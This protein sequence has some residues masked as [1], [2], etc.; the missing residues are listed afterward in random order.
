MSERE[1]FE[2][3]GETWFR[4]QYARALAR[5]FA[6]SRKTGTAAKGPHWD[7]LEA[8]EAVAKDLGILFPM[9][10]EQPGSPG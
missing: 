4:T 8:Y 7:V 2:R 10:P 1:Q 9:P 5:W 3:D 6:E